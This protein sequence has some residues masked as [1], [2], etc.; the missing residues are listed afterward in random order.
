[1]NNTTF[2]IKQSE[3]ESKL[4]KKIDEIFEQGNLAEIKYYVNIEWNC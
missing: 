4:N 2:S 1:M 3:I